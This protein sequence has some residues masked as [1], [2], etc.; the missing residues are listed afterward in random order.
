MDPFI[1]FLLLASGGFW[2]YRKTS[3]PE[4]L[5]LLIIAGCFFIFSP[6]LRW[7]YH[8]DI[9]DEF[10]T[11]STFQNSKDLLHFIFSPSVGNF[12]PGLR[13]LYYLAY[14]FFWVDPFAFRL[15]IV[16]TTALYGYIFMR[17]IEKLTGSRTA[18]IE[19]GILVMW[20]TDYHNAEL[21]AFQF[22]LTLCFVLYSLYGVLLYAETQKSIWRIKA[23]IAAFFA[24]LAAG[25]GLLTGLWLILFSL[26]CFSRTPSMTF[27]QRLKIIALPLLSWGASVLFV[28]L[29]AGTLNRILDPF[30]YFNNAAVLTVKSLGMYT[31]PSLLP[32]PEISLFIAIAA[33]ITAW[34]KRKSLPWGV[35]LFFVI[36]I[37]GHYFFIY[38]GRG[39]FGE[40]LIHSRRYGLCPSL[41]LPA[42]YAIIFT[43]LWQEKY[44]AAF[45]MR[46]HLSR[47]IPWIIIVFIAF[48]GAGQYRNIAE[49]SQGRG[50][51]LVLGQEFRTAVEGYLKESGRDHI[52]LA[53]RPVSIHP[54][55]PYDREIKR[56]SSF[57]L[58][59]TLHEKIIWS[60]ASDENFLDFVKS[61]QPSL[62]A[63][64]EM[65]KSGGYF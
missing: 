4:I 30:A 5:T 44:W 7:P 53:N 39:K 62:K 2:V 63:F 58:P 38:F 28:L 33:G 65:L 1:I 19:T 22:P 41:G 31:L 52:T 21:P 60:A 54:L 26:L 10:Y 15:V 6:S 51:L 8:L 40:I 25:A 29:K 36:W 3:R 34:Q 9:L 35:I 20:A 14:K 11:I 55:F 16:F 49:A 59:K 13:L 61:Q 43:V 23:S 64:S 12:I 37:I 24:P 50:D 48:Y 27:I 56:Y 32:W 17:L 57:L 46:L 42:I 18:A 47:I 45:W